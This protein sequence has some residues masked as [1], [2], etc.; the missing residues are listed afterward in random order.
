MS[1][2]TWRDDEREYAR[3]RYLVRVTYRPGGSVHWLTKQ[4]HARVLVFA[5]V[6]RRTS[7]SGTQAILK[8]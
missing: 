2:S 3:I 1:K 4:R 6:G 8:S 5:P 7:R